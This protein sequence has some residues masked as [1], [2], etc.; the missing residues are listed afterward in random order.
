MSTEAALHNWVGLKC[1][2]GNSAKHIPV[3][4]MLSLEGPPPVNEGDRWADNHAFIQSNLM[5][6]AIATASLIMSA[7]AEGVPQ[8]HRRQLF[9]VLH[10]LVNGEQ[11]DVADECLRVAEGGKWFLYEEISSGRDID[12]AWYAYEI[13]ELMSTEGGRLRFYTNEMRDNLP[14]D[15]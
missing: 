9:V 8:G 3:D 7:F 4:F 5:Q 14:P 1:G 6:P 13:L 15:L 10:A 11:D 2:C 12:N